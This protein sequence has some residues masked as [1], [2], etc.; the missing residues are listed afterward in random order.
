VTL[1]AF[2]LLISNKLELRTF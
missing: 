1:L 2:R